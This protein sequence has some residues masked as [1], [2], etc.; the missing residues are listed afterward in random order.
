MERP[1]DSR[2]VL[3]VLETLYGGLLADGAWDGFLRA[4][5]HWLHA[6]YAS[7][8]LTAPGKTV[9]GEVLTPD[10]DP[11]R[12]NDYAEGLFATDPFVGLPEGRVLAF[13]EFMAGRTLDEDWRRFLDESG[14]DQ[15]LGVDVRSS[16]GLEA[17]FR[18]TRNR[19]RPDFGSAERDALQA[20][21]PH[22]R[23]GV[24]LYERLQSSAIEHGVYRS[25][26]EQMAVAAI[27]LDHRGGV[28]HRN[29]VAEG[30]LAR[31]DGL[32]VH[33]G[34]LR[35]GGQAEQAELERLLQSP[36]SA[37]EVGRLRVTR[38]S[39]ERD[40]NLIVRPVGGR[41]HMGAG[42]PALALFVAD[43]GQPPRAS[44]E[45]LRDMFQLTRTEAAL[46]AALA[47]GSS[48]V[49]AANRLGMAHNTARAHL[50]AT[51]A[52][53][54][55]RRQSQLMRL[56]QTSLADLAGSETI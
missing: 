37:G 9:P 23:H 21:V 2:E 42:R 29:A 28:L 51:F 10:I 8:I 55:A 52:K 15:I 18:L 35:L 34:R 16:T 30:L 44:A 25:A 54:G 56:I 13:A 46:C 20:I 53:T 36:A 19:S 45:A 24:G 47:D 17:R 39:G 5:A 14:A 49:E 22:L 26:V 40:L 11:Q 32:S 27:I 43:P 3:T 38:P 33:A 41:D 7:L 4:L 48:L 12:V 6:T 1:D 50:R 31:A